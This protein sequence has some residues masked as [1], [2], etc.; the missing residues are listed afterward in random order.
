MFT[1]YSFRFQA[2]LVPTEEITI[3]VEV[4]AG[5]DVAAYNKLSDVS[6]SHLQYIQDSIKQPVLNTQPSTDCDEIIQEV[7]EVRVILAFFTLSSLDNL[8]N[9]LLHCANLIE[10]G[11]K[12]M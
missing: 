10:C 3:I 4:L 6:K 11:I 9:L 8:N 12:G 5:K 2:K 7:V 1:Y